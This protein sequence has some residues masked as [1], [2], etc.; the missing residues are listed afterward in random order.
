MRCPAFL[1]VEFEV[2]VG[3]GAGAGGFA[4]GGVADVEGALDGFGA[5]E[6]VADGE[7]L[8]AGVFA[9]SCSRRAGRGKCRSRVSGGADE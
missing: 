7:E 8:D 9:A 2:F 4:E 6:E 3:G 1:Q 5:F